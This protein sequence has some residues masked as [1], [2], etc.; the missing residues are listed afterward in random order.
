MIQDKECNSVYFS[1]FLEE[2]FPKMVF[3]LKTILEKYDYEPQFIPM[4]DNTLIGKR[5]SIWVRDY[6]PIQRDM[7]DHILFDYKPDYL[8]NIK[9]YAPHVPD[10]K[11]VL[12]HPLI[13]MDALDFRNGDPQFP[14]GL[15]IDG[16]NMLRCG[17]YI[18]MT[19]KVF[20]EN[21]TWTQQNIVNV[22]SNLFDKTIIFLPW[23]KREWC[24]HTDGILRYLGHGKVLLNTYGY[25]EYDSSDKFFMKRFYNRILPYFG[26]DNIKVLTF[27]HRKNPSEY[28][29]AYVNW[30]QL[31]KV[32]I[33]PKF[34]VAEDEEALRQIE[35]F[36]P[37]YKGKIE[38]VMIDS[39]YIEN[40][41]LK[42]LADLGG[43]LNCASWT[44]KE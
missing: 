12:L 4:L 29:W 30:L 5:L 43:C 32:L 16:G 42:N 41:K 7:C 34:G 26:K 33:I 22:I 10:G 28:R 8:V 1:E 24:G 35:T 18:I 21:P 14:E 13:G 38:Q 40:G 39:E 3:E 11:K 19:D 17:D 23:D 20:D 15:N 31:E 44:I 6:M 2:M 27:E 25:P 9:K 36:M 37:D